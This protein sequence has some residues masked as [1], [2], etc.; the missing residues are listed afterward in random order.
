MDELNTIASTKDMSLAPCT[1]LSI[2]NRIPRTANIAIYADVANNEVY[3][4]RV[5]VS[6]EDIW[7]DV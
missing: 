4:D 7:I 6:I 2:H 3:S 5:N 1:R